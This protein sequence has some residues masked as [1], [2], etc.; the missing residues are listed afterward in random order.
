MIYVNYDNYGYILG[1]RG[2]PDERTPLIRAEAGMY[3]V[4]ALR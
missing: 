4:D 3:T 2:R 1:A